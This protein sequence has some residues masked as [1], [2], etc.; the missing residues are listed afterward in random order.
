MNKTQI[1]V[2]QEYENS[3]HTINNAKY[4]SFLSFTP[5]RSH[6]HQLRENQYKPV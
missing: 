2:I 3:F 4:N 5:E 1:M 6:G